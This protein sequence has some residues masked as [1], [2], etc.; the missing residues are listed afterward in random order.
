MSKSNLGVLVVVL[1]VVIGICFYVAPLKEG[2]DYSRR[3]GGG[4]NQT[5]NGNIFTEPI[6]ITIPKIGPYEATGQGVPP[7]DWKPNRFRFKQKLPVNVRILIKGEIE[8][9]G[10]DSAPPFVRTIVKRNASERKLTT[11]HSIDSASL[12]FPNP[13]VIG[14]EGTFSI[15][16]RAPSEPGDYVLYVTESNFYK[17]SPIIYSVADIQVVER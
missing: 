3:V 9:I 15:G 8:V 11:H 14:R 1:A 6:V 10:G 17:P 7:E 13:K 12:K 4:I 2:L 5:E 16:T